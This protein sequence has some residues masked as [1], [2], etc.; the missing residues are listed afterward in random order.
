M[1]GRSCR[2]PARSLATANSPSP[3]VLR[4]PTCC[5]AARVK[6][7]TGAQVYDKCLDACLDA[8]EQTRAHY[9][10]IIDALQ[11]KLKALQEEHL[12]LVGER[13]QLEESY[14]ELKFKL[15]TMETERDEAQAEVEE[16]TKEMAFWKHH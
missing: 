10:P 14:N 11:Q 8:T 7:F 4:R 1:P 5:R 2:V 9:K 3:D 13:D 12:Q 15:Q 6:Q 16:L